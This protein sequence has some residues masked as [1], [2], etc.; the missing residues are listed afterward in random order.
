MDVKLVVG[1]SE[2]EIK[3]MLIERAKSAAGQDV[4]GMGATVDLG[5]VDS[6]VTGT[7]TMVAATVTFNG[8]A[9]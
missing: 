5:Y 9:K 7:K 6:D 4:V 2:K 8:K 3:D 1:F